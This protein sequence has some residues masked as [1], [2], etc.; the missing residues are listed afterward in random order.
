MANYRLLRSNREMG[1]YSLEEIIALGLKPYDLIWVDGKS[2]AWR[3]P[4]EIVELK[5]YSPIVEEQPYDRFFKRPVPVTE[6][7]QSLEK[8]PVEEKTGI[9]VLDEEQATPKDRTQS[10]IVVVMPK[11]DH[12]RVTIIKPFEPVREKEKIAEPLQKKAEIKPETTPVIPLEIKEEA[13]SGLVEM[14]TKMER[15]LDEIKDMYVKTLL[16]RKEKFNRRKRLGEWGKYA[17]G[18]L[19]VGALGTLMFLTLTN[20]PPRPEPLAST[21]VQLVNDQEAEKNR[22]PGLLPALT[23]EA[24]LPEEP[25]AQVNEPMTAKTGTPGKTKAVST[26]PGQTSEPVEQQTLTQ[27]PVI[28]PAT[29]GSR[30]KLTREKKDGTPRSNEELMRLVSVD[31]NDYKRLSFGGIK[32]LQLTVSNKSSFVLDQV[33]VELNYLKPSELPLKTET[34][35]FRSVA[36]NGSM[37]IRIPDSN[38]GIKVSYKVKEVV[39]GELNEEWAKNK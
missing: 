13:S 7:K 28:P 3:Y 8:K 5:P 6:S 19:F 11:K 39:S 9:A 35:T 17:A 24:S 38:R 14:E 15:S 2:A 22:Q 1:P 25:S 27:S 32:D 21:P 16:Q 36:P 4:S 26:N 10:P 20:K 30:E 34:V 37:T 12:T 31:A 23:V 18:G 29:D 33:V